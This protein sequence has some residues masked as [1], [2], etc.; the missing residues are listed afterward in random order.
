MPGEKRRIATDTYQA[1]TRGEKAKIV[2]EHI[3]IEE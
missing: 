2:V 1:D 3:L